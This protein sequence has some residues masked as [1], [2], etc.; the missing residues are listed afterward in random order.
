[1]HRGTRLYWRMQLGLGKL[2]ST[3]HWGTTSCQRNTFN[4]MVRWHCGNS[5]ATVRFHI[6]KLEVELVFHIIDA[7]KKYTEV[8]P[9]YFHTMQ[10]NQA[11]KS[12]SKHKC[13][14]VRNLDIQRYTKKALL[15]L[16]HWNTNIL[17][18]LQH[19]Y[20]NTLLNLQHLQKKKQKNWVYFRRYSNPLFF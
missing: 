5:R 16:Q 18:N 6:A 2:T 8:G 3:R 17:L 11:R 12:F 10:R 1:M 14:H 19:Q 4:F 20:T 9:K 15:N 7:S 13:T